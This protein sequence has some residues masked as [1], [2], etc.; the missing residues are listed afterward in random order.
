MKNSNTNDILRVVCNE[1]S[2]LDILGTEANY[3]LDE[4]ELIVHVGKLFVQLN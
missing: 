1:I 3:V 2:L 4:V